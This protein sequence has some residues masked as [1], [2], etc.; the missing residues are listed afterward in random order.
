MPLVD[1]DIN[2]GQEPFSTWMNVHVT[3]Q[4]QLHTAFW[5]SHHLH[6]SPKKTLL[7]THL[8]TCVHHMLDQHDAGGVDRG[9]VYIYCY[10][11]PNEL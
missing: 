5:M 4:R 7:P 2:K 6:G 10:V 3:Q 11:V 9:R 8:S 1:I